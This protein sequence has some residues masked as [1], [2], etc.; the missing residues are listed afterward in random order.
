VPSVLITGASR[1]IGRAIA[2]RLAVNGWETYAGVRKAADA[3][4]LAAASG[5]TIRPLVLDITDAEQVAA[6]DD[7]LP[8]TLDALVNNAGIVVAGPIEAVPLEELRRQLEVNVVGQVGVTQAL[9]PRLR[10]VRG[11]IVFVSSVSGRISNPMTGAYSGSK[12]ALEAIADALR[13]ELRPWRIPVVLVEPAQTD[14]DMWRTAE[15]LLEDVVGDLSPEM[16]ALYAG[17]IDGQRV[18]VPKAAKMAVPVE[19][20]AEVVE[21]SLTATR[22]KARYVV[23]AGPRLAAGVVPLMPSRLRDALLAAMNG[24]PRRP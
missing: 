18:A 24:V 11:R 19:N 1:G 15:E 9:L 10:P 22:P 14:T 23:G 6:L 20:V 2:L 7:A 21:R 16:R 5:G 13:M 12:F 8:A 17:H 3:D 4:E